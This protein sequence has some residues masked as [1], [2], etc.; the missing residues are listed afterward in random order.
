MDNTCYFGPDIKG[1]IV[2]EILSSERAD[3]C[4]RLFCVC[5]THDFEAPD[6]FESVLASRMAMACDRTKKRGGGP[7]EPVIIEFPDIFGP[8]TEEPGSTGE[9]DGN[10]VDPN[11]PVQDQE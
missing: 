11:E 1:Q 7:C 5:D 8:T 4:D 9:S 2:K 6:T 10:L 3:G